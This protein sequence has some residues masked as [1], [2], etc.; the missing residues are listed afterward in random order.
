MR[1]LSA[2]PLLGVVWLV[3][4]DAP[5]P[6]A[7]S[8]PLPGSQLLLAGY[9][10]ANLPFTPV[11]INDSGAIVGNVNNT[12]VRSLNGV[13]TVL[14]PPPTGFTAVY[15]A[16][17]ITRNGHILGV[18]G[19]NILIWTSPS[20]PPQVVALGMALQ[21]SAMTDAH[22]VVG[23]TGGRAFRW[24]P[25]TG[26]QLL[27]SPAMFANPRATH[28]SRNGYA[29]GFAQP[30][31][32][33]PE[34]LVRWDPMGVVKILLPV[35]HGSPPENRP[36]DIDDFGNILSTSG[37]TTI[38]WAV[39]GTV[40][41]ISGVPTPTRTTGLSPL[42][43]IVGHTIGSSNRPWTLFQGSLTW[44]PVPSPADAADIPVGVN[45]CGTILARRVTTVV[46]DS[47]YVW[48][49]SLTCDQGGVLQQ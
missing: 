43:R 7:V 26:L 41:I 22:M 24:T 12:A 38:R 3:A 48:R 4:C 33:G 29:A 25:A 11:A 28:V 44:L 49:Q 6:T 21:P 17:D 20:L 23:N 39:D 35:G 27:A 16:V 18:N 31:F 46:L 10:R 45:A 36:S 19:G 13:L 15:S 34:A 1:T 5:A 8:G 2:A 40:S 42:G 30:V 37:G 32:S 47:G 9:Q 14:P